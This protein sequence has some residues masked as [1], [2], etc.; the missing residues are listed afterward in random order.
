M[1]TAFIVALP[2]LERESVSPS[3]KEHGPLAAVWILTYR[4]TM[5]TALPKKPSCSL[6]NTRGKTL[7]TTI[8]KQKYERQKFYPLSEVK[9]R[10]NST[11]ELLGN[12]IKAF[13][14]ITPPAI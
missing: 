8:N 14:T 12:A 1:N 3:L 11:L 7:P 4:Q 5:Q 6:T 13:V 9:Q 2:S 10:F